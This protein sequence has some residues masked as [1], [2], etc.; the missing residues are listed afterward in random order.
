MVGG[1]VSQNYGPFLGTLTNRRRIIIG[2]QTGTLILTTTHIG[3]S[4]KA[5]RRKGLIKGCFGAV[6]FFCVGFGTDT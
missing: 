6:F 3:E 4:C 1:T 2:T 5:S